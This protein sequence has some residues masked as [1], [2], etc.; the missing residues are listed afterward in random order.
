MSTLTAHS[1][2]VSRASVATRVAFRPWTEATTVSLLFVGLT[3]AMTW[4]WALHMSD[5]INPFGDVIVQMTSL[6]WNAHALL[7]NPSSLFEAPFFYPY[8]HSLAFSENLLGETILALPI[9]LLTGNAA[10]AANYNILVSFV[11]TGLF[12]YLLAR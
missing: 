3:V 12:T 10:L 11:L 2:S 6:R 7:T 4:P 1:I 8:A 5:A 9:L